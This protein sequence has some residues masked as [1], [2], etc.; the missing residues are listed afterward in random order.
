MKRAG[1]VPRRKQW[2]SVLS[3][4]QLEAIHAA[5]LEVLWQTGCVVPLPEARELLASAGARVEGECAY[6]PPEAV[7]RAL[8]T[9]RPVT[10]FNRLG[11]PVMPLAEGRVNFGALVDRTPARCAA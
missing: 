1:G 8:S 3:E 5:S 2:L 6:I 11:E 4:E 7:E 10:L 9:V